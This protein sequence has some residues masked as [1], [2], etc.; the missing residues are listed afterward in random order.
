LLAS[1]SR[2]NFSHQFLASISLII[3][4]HQFLSSFFASSVGTNI[5]LNYHYWIFLSDLTVTVSNITSN[6]LDSDSNESSRASETLAFETPASETP[7]SAT[8]ASST[9]HLRRILACLSH[10]LFSQILASFSDTSFC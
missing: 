3:L 10:I 8:V 5:C 9:Q 7:A 4:S 6:M 2:I 1:I